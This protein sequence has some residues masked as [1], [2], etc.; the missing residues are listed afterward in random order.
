V[1]ETQHRAVLAVYGGELRLGEWHNTV[2][3][4]MDW[5]T[6]VCSEQAGP[7]THFDCRCLSAGQLKSDKLYSMRARQAALRSEVAAG[8]VR[9]ISI[10]VL[11]EEASSPAFDWTWT[12]SISETDGRASAEMGISAETLGSCVQ[13]QFEALVEG[14]LRIVSSACDPHFGF[15]VSMP[16]KFFPSGYVAGIAGEGPKELV[17]EANWWRRFGRRQSERVIRNVY[18]LTLLGEQHLRIPVGQTTLGEWIAEAPER[19]SLVPLEG[20]L[21]RWIIDAAAPFPGIL[22]WDYPAVCNVRK[23]LKDHHVFPWQSEVP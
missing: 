14:L 6:E 9:Q 3:A 16:R 11:P 13:P 8:N 19:G 15:A 21:F 18:G 7:P 22:A 2:S 4:F 1:T 23:S 5:A 12:A 17:R 20:G 10:Y